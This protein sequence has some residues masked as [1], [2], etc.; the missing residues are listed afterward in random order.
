MLD[1]GRLERGLKAFSETY[2]RTKQDLILACH[3]R[4]A[5]R[6]G[7]GTTICN[8]TKVCS[9]MHVKQIC[10]RLPAARRAAARANLVGVLLAPCSSSKVRPGCP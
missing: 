9:C 7:G 1:S 4:L 5:R 10:A 8:V 2:A 3:L 6:K